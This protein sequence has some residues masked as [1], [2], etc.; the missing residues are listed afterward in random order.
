MH[1]KYYWSSVHRLLN[2]GLFFQKWWWIFL[3]PPI[4]YPVS[5]NPNG[6]HLRRVWQGLNYILK[7]QNMCAKVIKYT[8]LL[9]F[10]LGNQR[11]VS[12]TT[13]LTQS[14]CSPTQTPKSSLFSELFMHELVEVELG[15]NWRRK[16]QR[17]LLHWGR[18]RQKKE[19]LF[20]GLVLTVQ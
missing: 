14:W 2:V 1:R 4:L 17:Q 20:R 19:E 15:H 9:L 10:Y 12:T 11:N 5:F 3:E 18:W 13:S 7:V 6:M 8:T 16:W